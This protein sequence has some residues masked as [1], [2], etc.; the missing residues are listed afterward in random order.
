MPLREGNVNVHIYFIPALRQT[1]FER[2]NAWFLLEC[3]LTGFTLPMGCFVLKPSNSKYCCLLQWHLQDLSSFRKPNYWTCIAH[4][5]TTTSERAGLSASKVSNG[6]LRKDD[7]N[8][9]PIMKNKTLVSNENSNC[10]L[11]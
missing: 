1:V 11:Y 9:N 7:L 6:N 8:E 10:N 5:V 2:S 3:W 4:A